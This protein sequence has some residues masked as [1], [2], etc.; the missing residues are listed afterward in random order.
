MIEEIWKLCVND[1]YEVSNHGR[2]RRAT[3]GRKTNAG[4]LIKPMLL[5]IGYYYVGPTVNGKNKHF[6]IHHLVAEHFIGPRPEKMDINHKDGN[7]TNNHVSNLEYV[8]HGD[9]MRHAFNSGLVNCKTI[10][11]PEVI[12]EIRS[13]R[14]SGLS[15]SKIAA[16][17]GVSIGYAWQICNGNLRKGVA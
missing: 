15:Y 3:P 11:S 10:H 6:Y 1:N 16:A 9:N 2:F 4:Q 12:R 13:L 14:N 8:T 17:T 7:K 5:K